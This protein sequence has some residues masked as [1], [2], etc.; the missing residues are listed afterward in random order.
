[1]N[2]YPTFQLLVFVVSIGLLLSFPTAP[3]HAANCDGLPATSGALAAGTYTLTDNCVITGTFNITSGTVTINGGGFAIDRGGSYRTFYVMSGATLELNNVT[4]RNGITSF[5][6]GAIF[7][8][9]GGTVTISNSTLS[10][11]SA[12]DYGGAIYNAGMVTINNSTLSGNSAGFGG[13][14]YN[15]GTVTISNSTL[16]GNSATTQG[17]A[18]YNGVTVDLT[19]TIISANTAPSGGNC[20]NSGTITD[21]GGNLEDANDCGLSSGANTDPLLGAFNGSY[22]PLQ[23]GSPAIDAAPT[24]PLSTDQIGTPRPQGSACDIG[25]IEY[26]TNPAFIPAP[27]ACNLIEDVV[28]PDL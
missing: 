13:A 21:N 3:A 24:C 8:N 19:N 18:I 5:S 23:A 20:N 2:K 9:F 27:P 25:A 6:G 16:S 22:Y 14:I 28:A 1:M 7:N 26:T 4:V 11:N 10:G 17:G 15:F 12:T